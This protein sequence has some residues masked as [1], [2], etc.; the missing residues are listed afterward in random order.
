MEHWELLLDQLRAE[1]TLRE[2][3]LDLLH[4]IDLRL[5][6]PDQTAQDIFSFI[7]K[8]TQRLLRSNHTT[9]LMRRSTFLEPT[10]SNLISVVGQ[11]V[12]ISESLTG[13][14]L[15]EDRTISVP[16]LTAKPYRDRY[17]PL[18]GY[19]GARMRSLLATPIQI[20][21]TAVGVLNAES[22]KPNAF[23][24]V[25]ER[26]AASVAAQIAIAL[27][28]TQTLA[29]TEL[30][31]D[32]ERLI[33]ADNV[34]DDEADDVIADETEKVIQE[35]LKRVMS[36]LQQIEHVKHHR[37]DILFLRGDELEI[38]HSTNP[39][40]VGLTVPVGN[41]IS[42]RAI[43]EKR[44]II[45]GDV[46]KEP[47][48]QLATES[49][50]SEIA[51]PILLGDDNDLAIGVLNVEST[52]EDAFY[53]FYQVV[54]ESFAEKVKTLLA[55]AKLQ[56]DVTEALDL[57][58]ANEVLAA[59]GDQT[60]HIVHRLNNTVGMM[61][62]RI[63]ELQR[64]NAAGTLDG[65]DFLTESLDSLRNL[66]ERTLR[67]PGE[68]TQTL[69]P[70]GGH[71]DVNESVHRALRQTDPGD[72]VQV[73]LRLGE[74]IPSLPLLNFDIVVQNLI[75][76]ALD[77]MP[78]GGSLAITTSA[79]IHQKLATGYFQLTV[80]D[81]GA[82]IPPEIRKRIFELNFTTKGTRG[83]GRGLGLW[84]VRKF[85]RSA[86]GDISIRSTPGS[87]TEVTVKIP[88]EP[89]A[90]ARAAGVGETGQ[91]EE[92]RWDRAETS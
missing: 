80:K 29:S 25:H 61:R 15:E 27:Q 84:W 66:A 2:A 81:N 12:L 49:I 24:P 88:V 52:E 91:K 51:V 34:Y 48:Y 89:A 21:G 86:K 23:Q 22:R 73:I 40:D 32:V 76:N 26:M 10:Y 64:R 4:K 33:F 69:S 79:V 11:R 16:D 56:A 19:R 55:F 87:G 83:A 92:S 36:A 62:V 35:A 44:T 20:R 63:M 65:S 67:M 58:T 68:V 5:L 78:D 14:S 50:R 37:A 3:E 70:A 57:R 43:R 54:L 18:R 6:D 31:A 17:A 38:M 72:K 30:F 74:D 59:V 46:T 42:G 47:E 53:D 8:G 9:I 75:Q 28:Q 13:L 1:I 85:V 82:G 90:G 41:S 77:A 60:S 39:P 71:V 45:V 7:V